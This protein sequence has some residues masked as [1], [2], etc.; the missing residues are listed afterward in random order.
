MALFKR[1]TLKDKGFTDEQIEFVMS[2]SA[3]ALAADYMLKSDLEAE[4]AKAVE[5]AK[6]GFIVNVEDTDQYKTLLGQKT[7]IEAQFNSYKERQTARTS[8]DFKGVKA[9]FFD[10]VYDKVDKT[11][12]IPEQLTAIKAEYEEYFEAEK[13]DPK[14]T[15]GAPSGGSMPKGKNNSLLSAWG[16]E[17]NKE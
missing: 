1:S 6:K 2:E 8:E 3:R 9:K 14:P 10:Q 16:Y 13:D 7:D 15:F 5:D 11:K 4:K 12:P 17:R